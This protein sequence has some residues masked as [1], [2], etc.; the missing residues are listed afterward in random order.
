MMVQR[1]WLSRFQ[2]TLGSLP[3][4]KALRIMFLGTGASPRNLPGI[5]RGMRFSLRTLW[6]QVSA[7]NLESAAPELKVPVFF[8]NGRNDHQ[9]DA[10]VA[11]AYFEKL[12]APSKTLVWFE[13]SGHFA[14]FEEPDKFNAE[15]A[16]IAAAMK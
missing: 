2:G 1:G 3:M 10:Q 13:N 5:I 4:L 11:A 7:L 9:V 12:I 14:P 16:K 8:L 6:T 15:M